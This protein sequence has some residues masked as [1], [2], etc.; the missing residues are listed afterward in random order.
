MIPPQHT[1]PEPNTAIS[2]PD[3]DAP[4]KDKA[5]RRKNTRKEG[6]KPK[7]RSIRISKVHG[8]G[9]VSDMFPDQTAP[10]DQVENYVPGDMDSSSSS[11]EDEDIDTSSESGSDQEDA[12]SPDDSEDGDDLS[13]PSLQLSD[14]AM[15]MKAQRNNSFLTTLRDVSM[16]ISASQNH[17]QDGHHHQRRLHQSFWDDDEEGGLS[18]SSIE[19]GSDIGFSYRSCTGRSYNSGHS[20]LH[21]D[22]AS[23]SSGQSGRSGRYSSGRRWSNSSLTLPPLQV[24]TQEQAEEIMKEEV[25]PHPKETLFEMLRKETKFTEQTLTEDHEYWDTYFLEVTPERVNDFQSKV[26]RLVTKGNLDDLKEHHQD[27]LKEG[28]II[29]KINWNACNARG[30]SYLQLACRANARNMAKYLMKQG[31]TLK[32]RDKFGR[33]PLVELGWTNKPDF[34]LIRVVLQRAPALLFAIDRRQFLPFQYIPKDV[35]KDWNEFLTTTLNAK[36]L[37]QFCH[38]M[39]FR[40]STQ[41]LQRNQQRL[42]K[43]LNDRLQSK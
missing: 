34:G 5:N 11:D 17:H 1:A 26:A 24:M 19:Q 13:L 42:M 6:G 43:L 20:R 21:N 29:P 31:A 14:P 28:S 12:T 25:I 41:E 35:H 10:W 36:P 9:K 39:T 15:L 3:S 16:S 23:R 4:T 22:N 18:L 38:L 30:E 27:S 37:L 40:A 7:K 33:S 2:M 8:W 32:V